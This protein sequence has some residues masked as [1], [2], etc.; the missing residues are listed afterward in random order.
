MIFEG[1]GWRLKE[2]YK[3]MSERYKTDV[4]DET[5]EENLER[6]ILNAQLEDMQKVDSIHGMET[7]QISPSCMNCWARRV[8]GG[9]ST[10][11]ESSIFSP[12][13]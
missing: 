8:R 12:P 5:K 13:R 2:D 3:T 4:Y 6:I 11:R 7:P 9:R 1:V 10:K